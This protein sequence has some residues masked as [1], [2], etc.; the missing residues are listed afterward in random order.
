[1]HFTNLPKKS[2]IIAITI[3]ALSLFLTR[4][5]VYPHFRA[6]KATKTNEQTKLI[7]VSQP[8]FRVKVLEPY[9][10][11]TNTQ[12]DIIREY[13]LFEG[14]QPQ[15]KDHTGRTNYF[16]RQDFYDIM[17]K[18][19][20]SIYPTRWTNGRENMNNFEYENRQVKKKHNWY[21]SKANYQIIQTNQPSNSPALITRD[22]EGDNGFWN[23]S[24]CFL[25]S[26]E[27][28]KISNI[29]NSNVKTKTPY[30]RMI[31]K[32]LEVSFDWLKLISDEF[33]YYMPLTAKAQRY[34]KK[35][36]KYIALAQQH[37]FD[38]NWYAIE[39]KDYEDKGPNLTEWAEK[40]VE[41]AKKYINKSQGIMIE[42]K[43][44]NQPKITC[45]LT[46]KTIIDDSRPNTTQKVPYFELSYDLEKLINF[47]NH[48]D[49]TNNFHLQKIKEFVN[50]FAPRN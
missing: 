18:Y 2:R 3:I 1:M 17:N 4:F 30:I 16:L 13:R 21:V 39:A 49:L 28:Q 22:I 24:T 25:N 23:Q 14:M 5:C 35:A 44:V 12:G 38:A 7:E 11:Y 31:T 50:I 15:G 32:N 27:N 34:T 46:T 42:L 33:Y 19:E 36:Q 29:L 6:K 43:N 10:Q 26:I 8:N 40:Y 37:I 41:L 9:V 45:Q 48:L 47:I 20:L